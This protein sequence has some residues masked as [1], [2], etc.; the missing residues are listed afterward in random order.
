[1]REERAREGDRDRQSQ[2]ENGSWSAPAPSGSGK[3]DGIHGCFRAGH[4]SAHTLFD[5]ARVQTAATRPSYCDRPGAPRSFAPCWDVVGC[6]LRYARYARRLQLSQF[7][8]GD[9]YFRDCWAHGT[10][11]CPKSVSYQG[12]VTTVKQELAAFCPTGFLRSSTLKESYT[13]AATLR[14]YCSYAL[15]QGRQK[16]Q[17]SWQGRTCA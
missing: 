1:M 8:T 6:G 13:P 15:S 16:V 14:Q 9:A 17:A 5:A 7:G 2:R 10:L 3:N 12:D 4:R 11:R